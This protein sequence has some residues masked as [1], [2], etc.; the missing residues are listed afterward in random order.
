MA[1]VD[2]LHKVV[3]FLTA[4]VD[5]LHQ[6]VVVMVDL[7]HKVVEVMVDLLHKVVEVMVDLLHKL[8]SWWLWWT[9]FLRCKSSCGHNLGVVPILRS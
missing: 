1:M 2:L 7:L 3:E 5:L 4:I 6:V 8:S 9:S